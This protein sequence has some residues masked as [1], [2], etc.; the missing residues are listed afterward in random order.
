MRVYVP[1]CRFDHLHLSLQLART[2][3]PRPARISPAAARRVD[4]LPERVSMLRSQLVDLISVSLVFLCAQLSLRI[5][6]I[7]QVRT[8]LTLHLEPAP[9]E[10][11]C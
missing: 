7:A 8:S 4:H 11:R 9:K 6:L 5:Q 2:S 10:T 1:G 3:L